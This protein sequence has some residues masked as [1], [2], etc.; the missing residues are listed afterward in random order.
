M[1]IRLALLRHAATEWNRAQRLQG[2]RDIALSAA[3]RSQ[4]ASW[5][6]P[7]ELRGWRCLASPLARAL[8]TARLLGFSA[9]HPEP[10]LIEMDWGEWEGETVA[11]LR[12]RLGALMAENEA[13]GLD[14][15]PPGGESPR[16]VMERL[17]NWLGTLTAE[18]GPLLCI[19]HK[20]VIRAALALATGWNMR[21]KPPWRLDWT[22]AQVFHWDGRTL[23]VER[24]NL[25]LQPAGD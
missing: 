13:R 20:G 11:G 24:L 6:L 21:G 3:G 16:Q 1:S 12:A 15:C 22:C 17:Q 19:T 23:H 9:P 25:P 18:H 8:E 10:A 5:R 4:A 7:A 14:F 2:R